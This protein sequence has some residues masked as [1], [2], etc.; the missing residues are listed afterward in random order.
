MTVSIIARPAG[1]DAP[2]ATVVA[3]VAHARQVPSAV[4]E[5]FAAE[6]AAL[7]PSEAM[8][9]VH[10][11]HRVE[12]YIALGTFGERPLPKPP[13]GARRLEDADAARHLTSVACGLDSAVLGEN[14]VLHQL[15]EALT[16][17]RAAQPLD[18]VLDRLFQ[19]AL[20]AGRRAHGWFNGW[21]RSLADVALERIAQRA[22]PL[23]G[24]PILVVGAGII[25]RLAALAAARRG[26]QVIVTN[27]TDERAVALAREVGG[28]AI[29]F[30]RDGV[31]PPVAGAVVALGGK[32]PVCAE[33]A[34]QLAESGAIVVDL[35]SPPAVADALQAQ[36][37]DR[38]VS[39]DDLA[40]GE[41]VELQDG[42]RGRL[43]QLV[44]ESGRAYCH[45]LRSRDALPAIQ[46]IA[47]AAEGQRRSQLEWLLRR[48]PGLAEEERSLIE[49][50]SHRLVAGILHAPRSAL[51]SDDSGDLGRAARELF[52]V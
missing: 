2:R 17:R 37:G 47:E 15:R 16:V 43:E 25:G 1:V 42:L 12:V 48:L 29:P 8:I 51:N 18:P 23:E 44:S 9:V 49:Q 19:V 35:S 13:P 32:W 38:F 45:W 34:R 10:T 24:Q 46:A 26:A 52:G 33:D 14:E 40:W 41:D 31:L 30:A 21:Q 6:L 4:R 3:F 27:R 7:E 39:V 50:M 22:G 36:L 11:C 5:A 20:H 28:R